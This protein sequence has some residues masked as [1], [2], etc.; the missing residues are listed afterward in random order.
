MFAFSG[1]ISEPSHPPCLQAEHPLGLRCLTLPPPWDLVMQEGTSVLLAF[2]EPTLVLWW[3]STKL[4]PSSHSALLLPT[5]VLFA[6]CGRGW[7][8][9]WALRAH[10]GPPWMSSWS[11]CV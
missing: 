8:S 10:A 4:L 11:R 5:R 6:G 1:H 7:S 2:P 9:L 3:Q